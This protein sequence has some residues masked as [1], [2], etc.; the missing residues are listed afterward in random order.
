MENKTISYKEGKIY[1]LVSKETDKIIYGS[2]KQKLANR[3]GGLK[4]Y[5]RKYL[6]HGIGKYND[7]FE[8]LKFP[9]AQIV[10]KCLYPCNS[11]AELDAKEYE[12]RNTA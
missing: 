11:K 5:Y 3:L 8:I 4:A 1:M 7:S 2:T 9:D 6:N 12:V 10:L